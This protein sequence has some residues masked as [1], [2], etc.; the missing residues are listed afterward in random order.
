MGTATGTTKA[1]TGTS[2]DSLAQPPVRRP[3][4]HVNSKCHVSIGDI[5]TVGEVLQV[6]EWHALAMGPMDVSACWNT[7]GKLVRRDY[8]QRDW[9]R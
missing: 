6:H 9:L 5:K 7:L 8:K 1:S 4:R 3:R 2:G